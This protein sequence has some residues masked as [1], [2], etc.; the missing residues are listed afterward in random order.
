MR[1]IKIIVIFA[2]ILL[3][4]FSANAAD[5]TWSGGGDASSYSDDSNWS[6]ASTPTTAS[7]V[8]IDS[9]NA[10]VTASQT[11]NAKSLTIGGRNTSTLTSSNFVFGNISP[12]STSDTAI[13]IR[14]GGKFK[15]QGAGVVTAQGKYLDTE[16]TLI[17]E[18][19]FMLWV[20]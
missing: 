3:L 19:G 7:D 5:K 15:L 9:E 12:G 13:S 2:C 8:T 1:Y 16:G 10:S 4:S 17:S 11:Y 6:P 20:K 14:S 18:K